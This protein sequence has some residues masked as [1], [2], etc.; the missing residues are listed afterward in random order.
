MNLVQ[1]LVVFA[2]EMGQKGWAV[3]SRQ[4]RRRRPMTAMVD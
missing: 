1:S 2:V 3:I 4:S